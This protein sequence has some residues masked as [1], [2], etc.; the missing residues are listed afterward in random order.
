MHWSIRI[1]GSSRTAASSPRSRPRLAGYRRDQLTP[2][3]Q[4]I[5]DSL[6]ATPG[7]SA[8]AAAFYSPLS[9]NNWGSNIWIDGHPAPGPKE[10]SFSSMDRVTADFFDVVGNPIVRGRGITA[11]DTAT[12]RHV[13]VVNQAFARKFFKG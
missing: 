5:H 4:R 13:A 11:Q 10:N 2:L 1:L 9:G 7:V 8:V 6:A 12:S 3:Y